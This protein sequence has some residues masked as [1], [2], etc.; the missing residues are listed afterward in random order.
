MASTAHTP[1]G[2]ALIDL[3][4]ATFQFHGA[5]VAA[6][7]KISAVVGLTMARWQV[8]GALYRAGRPETVSNI[9]RY[10]GL[11][12]Q[13]VQRSADELEKLGLISYEN[14]PHHKRAPL[15]RLTPAGEAAFR[16]ISEMRAPWINGLASEL[17][18]E[19]IAVATKLLK[20]LRQKFEESVQPEA[21]ID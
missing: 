4:Y 19:D 21:Q 14:N 6:G 3:F 12:R 5:L 18:A 8:L 16:H 1:A 15:V 20:I 13:S 11:A 17:D 9:A 2:A 10:M 7:D